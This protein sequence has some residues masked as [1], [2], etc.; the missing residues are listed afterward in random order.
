MVKGAGDASL[1]AK[2]R[3]YESGALSLVLKPELLLPTGREDV[4]LGA[5]HTRW[6]VIV[7][8]AYELGAVRVHRQPG[9]PAQPQ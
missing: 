9:L 8:A 7:A 6:G 2:W 1:A 4:G 3:F 5:G